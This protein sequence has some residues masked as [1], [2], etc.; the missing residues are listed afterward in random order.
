VPYAIEKVNTR[1]PRSSSFRLPRNLSN[2]MDRQ[3]RISDTLLFERR[4]NHC[5]GGSGEEGQR[6]PPEFFNC[7]GAP[8]TI[9]RNRFRQ[10]MWSGGPIRQIVLSY[11]GARLQWLAESIPGLLKRLKI[12]A[13]KTKEIGPAGIQFKT[14]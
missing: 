7:L 5:S 1:R 2:N 3:A 12:R 4:A 11:R 9:A 10:P 13:L 6:Q 8:K 14:C